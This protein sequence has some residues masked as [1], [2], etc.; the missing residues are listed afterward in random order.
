LIRQR[1]LTARLTSLFGL[2]SVAVLVGLSL[3][4]ISAI[5]AHFVEQDTQLLKNELHLIQ[6]VV[7]ERGADGISPTFGESL[8]KHPGFYVDIRNAQGKPLYSTL[9]AASGA[10]LRE[11]AS[12]PAEK[13]FMVAIDEHQRFQAMRAKAGGGD[14][15]QALD[16]VVAVDT[17]MHEHFMTRFRVTLILYVIAAAFITVLLGWWAARR[18]LA[19]LRTMAAR[20]QAVTSHNFTERMPVDTVPVE[21]AELAVKL[22]AM[23]E[24]LQE[25]FRRLTEFSSD[26]AHELRTPLTNLLTQT[27]VVLA[28]DRTT[29]AYRDTLSSNAEEIQRLSRTISDMLYLAQMENGISLPSVEMLDVAQET[30]DLFDFYDALAEEKGVALQCVGAGHVKGDRLMLRRA[31]SNLLSNALRYTPAG[32]VITVRI[33]A[34]ANKV[35]VSVENENGG[36]DIPQA[37]LPHLFDRFFRGEK[38]RVR[39]DTDTSGLG[40]SITK[41]IVQAHGGEIFVVSQGGRTSF[42]LEF[43]A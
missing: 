5:K 12:M 33:T 8:H 16:V 20:A 24:R 36:N 13:S 4:I 27:H 38:S 43:P 29:T 22:N 30:R 34:A 25:D 14:A 21:I 39:P 41:A 1:S 2:T 32:G 17:A 31:L 9:G 11:A 26:L 37:M 35:A 3:L 15:R 42:I 10:I 40:L 6:M 28:Q 23:L 19:P 18:G 7:S